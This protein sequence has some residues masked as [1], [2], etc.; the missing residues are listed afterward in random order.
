MLQATSAP[1]AND[2]QKAAAG[3]RVPKWVIALIAA[4]AIVVLAVG[5]G[6]GLPLYLYDRDQTRETDVRSALRTIQTGI[7]GY[8]LHNNGT[9]PQP[10]Q[11]AL[12][13]LRAYVTKWPANP[14]TGEPMTQGKV[15]GGYAYT[16]SGGR[17]E[18]TGYGNNGRVVIV[19]P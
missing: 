4:A 5:L 15:P 8:V 10:S 13:G 11:V 18:L 19:V 12:G 16:V 9:L 2:E 3:G 6:I 14:Y 1:A 17:F 7:H